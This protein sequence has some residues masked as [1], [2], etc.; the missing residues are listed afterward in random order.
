MV[1]ADF[2]RDY[3]GD[4]NLSPNADVQEIKK[5]FK[6]LALTYHP[7][8][9]PGRET[10]VTAQF[11]L[12]QSAHE[13]L[14]DTQERAKY[15]ANRRT[16]AY[17]PSYTG[18]TSSGVRGNPWQNAGSQ[19]PPP[20]KPSGT[21][22]A[23]PPPSEGAKRYQQFNNA[24]P[25][26]SQYSAQEGAE[27][28]RSTYAAWEHMRPD[29]TRK[30]APTRATP[31]RKPPPPPR[32]T[33][34][35]GHTPGVSPQRKG[36]MPNTPGGDEPAAPRGAYFTTQRAAPEPPP[37]P[38]RNPSPINPSAS[39]T[40]AGADPLNQFRDQRP[41]FEPRTSTP[42]ATHGGEKFNLHESA[43]IGRSKSTRES[44]TTKDVPRTGSDPNL[45]S[46]LRTRSTTE[47]TSARTRKPTPASV[48]IESEDS[49][50]DDLLFTS[51]SFGKPRRNKPPVN[52]ATPLSQTEPNAAQGS[53]NPRKPT[54]NLRTLRQWMMENP[55]A[56]YLLNRFPTDLPPRMDSAQQ[57]GQSDEAKMYA[58]SERLFTPSYPKEEYPLS[59]FQSDNCNIPKVSETYKS[60]DDTASSKFY[61]RGF[62]TAS[63]PNL[64][65]LGEDSATPPSGGAKAFEEL[66]RS[67]IDGLLSSKR[68]NTLPR[69][70]TAAPAEK[71]AQSQKFQIP[72]NVRTS[73]DQWHTYREA[74][75]GSPLK[76]SKPQK[77]L[78]SVHSDSSSKA[79]VF[80]QNYEQLKTSNANPTENSSFTFN[81][82]NE[83]FQRTQPPSNGFASSKPEDITTTFTQESWGKDKFDGVFEAGY[84]NPVKK[85]PTTPTRGRAR[86]G[87]RSRSPNKARPISI[88]PLEP[89][90]ATD[91]A[92]DMMESPG[93]TKFQKNAWQGVFKP[94]TFAPT[95]IPPKIPPPSSARPVNK[96]TRTTSA[97][98]TMGTA[99]VVNDG[100]MSDHK[101]LFDGKS[102]APSA[103]RH[104]PSPDAMDVDTPPVKSAHTVPKFVPGTANGNTAD[105]TTN[106]AQLNGNVQPAQRP[107]RPA[108]HSQS[109]VEAES[110]RVNLQDLKVKDIN[111]LITDLN[112][113]APP[114]APDA[115]PPPTMTESISKPAQDKYM[116]QFEVYMRDWDLFNTKMIIHFFARKNQAWNST[117]W[118]DDSKIENY[119]EALRVDAV[120]DKH[121][122]NAR[123]LHEK[124]M[125]D[126]VVIRERMKMRAEFEGI[127]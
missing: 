78:H 35:A 45:G 46:P 109:P 57:N 112:L 113:P 65:P 120:V 66:Q 90:V 87:S 31:S 63:Y 28:R 125:K 3:Y 97:R 2:T 9:N 44:A 88:P 117:G 11:Q 83:T 73:S 30:P 61:S 94:A 74:G 55:G 115:P 85:P 38:P 98:P 62:S 14:T 111:E 56:E 101:P 82:N 102:T 91:A 70:Q 5:Q 93:G 106:G 84:F 50:S 59:S 51:G 52:R 48:H 21:R 71:D 100:E 126:Y 40:N 95:F 16:A 25:K 105:I 110:L 34:N 13:V 53:V 23:A 121:W 89:Q 26:A 124:V 29:H 7:D 27:A 6:K 33:P 99:A 104:P 60:S 123:E 127:R 92:E 96:K 37:V 10:Q 69:H 18:P 79:R 68:R 80:W 8:R 107:K 76:K 54:S 32:Q 47:R 72:P 22:R 15:D 4:L 64:F 103:F 43:N 119:R 77:H 41:Q 19:F 67:V 108:T 42:Y 39:T 17:R 122:H 116:K 58:K 114:P 20:P 12:I 49:G 24:A 81:V 36:F 86:N 1:K 75:E 118:E